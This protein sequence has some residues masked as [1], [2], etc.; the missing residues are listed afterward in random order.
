MRYSFVVTL[1][2]YSFSRVGNH[3]AF[4]LKLDFLFQIPDQKDYT[5]SGVGAFSTLICFPLQL[6]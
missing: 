2:Q 4:R 6:R 1:V 5:F 3:F